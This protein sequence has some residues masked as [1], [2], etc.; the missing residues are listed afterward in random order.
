[1]NISVFLQ[2]IIK[3]G[4]LTVTVSCER[5]DFDLPFLCHCLFN[6]HAKNT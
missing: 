3:R 6:L 4:K 5:T 2:E 1:M